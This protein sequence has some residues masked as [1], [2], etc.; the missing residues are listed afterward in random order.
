M[1][2]IQCMKERQKRIPLAGAPLRSRWSA[3]SGEAGDRLEEA[4]HIGGEKAAEKE[5]EGAEGAHQQP[6]E[7]H[8]EK[9][10]PGEKVVVAAYEGKGEPTAPVMAMDR[11]KGRGFS[12]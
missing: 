5:G 10:L 6:D 1:P 2:P 3:G 8:G 9:A 4:V 7:G 11:R 12:R